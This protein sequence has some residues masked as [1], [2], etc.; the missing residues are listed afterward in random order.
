MDLGRKPLYR[1]QKPMT[2]WREHANSTR[3]G[4]GQTTD[5]MLLET[6]VLTN[7]T[8]YTNQQKVNVVNVSIHVVHY[9]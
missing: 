2:T 9:H 7:A 8:V 4:P 5:F 1:E 6:T 3:K